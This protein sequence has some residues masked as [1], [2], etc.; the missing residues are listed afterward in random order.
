MYWI[1]D[2]GEASVRAMVLKGL[3]GRALARSLVVWTE[4]EVKTTWATWMMEDLLA[5]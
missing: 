2:S 5:S 1:A 3:L 4:S